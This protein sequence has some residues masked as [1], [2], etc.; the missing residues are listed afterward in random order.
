MHRA[1]YSALTFIGASGAPGTRTRWPPKQAPPFPLHV[2]PGDHR[3]P[4][5]GVPRPGGLSTGEDCPVDPPADPRSAAVEGAER[6]LNRLAAA[7]PAASVEAPV[8]S[9]EW[10]VGPAEA[11]VDLQP[12]P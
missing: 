6:W 10:L 5:P 2:T 3:Q 9:V 7:D 12:S 11:F 1:A 8:A 4:S